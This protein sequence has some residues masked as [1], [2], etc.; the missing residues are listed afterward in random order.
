MKKILAGLI[1]LIS[2][3]A[4]LAQELNCQVSVSAPQVEGT[5]KRIFQ[6]LQTAV[7]EFVN[8]RKWSNYN[9]R[10]EER[11]E[12]TIL[13]TIS[14]RLGS[15]GF[16]GS[17]NV[18]LRRPILNTAYNSVLLNWVDK[19]M[20]FNYVE[21]QPL[22]YSD[23]VFSSNLTSMLAYYIYVFL[24][25]EFDS[26]SPSGGIPFFQKAQDVVTAAQ[27]AQEPG[28]KA[29]DSQR[30]R[31]WLVENYLNPANSGLHDFMY[32]YHRLGLDVMYEKVDQGRANITQSLDILKNLYD[33]KPDLMA[34]Q[35]ILDAKRDELVNIYSDQR[36]PPMERTTVS[37]LLKEIDPANSSKYQTIVE[38]K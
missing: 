7:Y 24:G 38:G 10:M 13:I 8:N 32:Q 5:D 4:V 3:L 33:A 2:P 35:L 37:N 1:L 18:V 15:D 25:L 26:F 30:N 27:N 29:Y 14:D 21:F 31:Y 11:I 17:M 28:W 19:D 16:K 34:L 36:V 22:D 20:Q 12:C 23:G 6:T 9:I